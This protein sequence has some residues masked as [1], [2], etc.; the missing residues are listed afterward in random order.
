[1]TIQPIPRF[2]AQPT[3]HCVTGSMRHIYCFYDHDISEE[4]L[5]G[6]GQ[7]VG[8]IYWHQKGADPF[9]GGRA[10]PKPGMEVLAGQR[11]GVAVTE[12]TTTSARKARHS[13]LDQLVAGQPVM[14]QVDMGF[15][16]YFDFQDTGYH[17]GGHVIVACGYDETADQV[18]VADRDGLYPVP[19]ADLEKARGSTFKPFPPKNK[20]FA[21]DFGQK[22]EPTA[23]EIWGAIKAQAELML[24]PPIRNI[25]VAGI[26]KTAAMVPKWPESMNRKALQWALFNAYIFIS[27]VGG[28]GGG[29]FRYMFG[30][31]LEETAVITAERALADSAEQFRQ[32]GQAWEAAGDWFRLISEVDDPAPR[33]PEISPSLLQIADME[34]QAWAQLH[35]LAA[36]QF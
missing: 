4:M 17:F 30:R 13:L 34:Q 26:R 19:L 6:L 1:M 16:P 18:L 35:Q 5:L 27:P 24:N 8:F 23:V 31:F 21:F 10:T 14:L 25:G 29:I 36:N 9:L 2:Q 7:G 22:R 28:T 11:T 32:I 3:H 12:H 33:L 20:W 15:L